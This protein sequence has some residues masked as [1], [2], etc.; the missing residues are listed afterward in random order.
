MKYFRRLA[1]GRLVE[2]KGPDWDV[3]ESHAPYTKRWCVPGGL[4]IEW[5]RG[6]DT[7]QNYSAFLMESGQ[8]TRPINRSDAARIIVGVRR[9]MRQLAKA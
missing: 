7:R 2:T 9:N 8:P 5:Y 1:D 3:C 6:F 4:A